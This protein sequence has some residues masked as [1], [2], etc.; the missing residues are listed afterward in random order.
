MIDKNSMYTFLH[1]VEET[2]VL[3]IDINDNA[4]I[5]AISVLVIPVEMHRFTG[6]GEKQ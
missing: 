5:P 1:S 6:S 3:S 4:G 2:D